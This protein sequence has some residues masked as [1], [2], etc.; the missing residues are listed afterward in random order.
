MPSMKPRPTTLLALFLSALG[1]LLAKRGRRVAAAVIA[2]IVCALFVWGLFQTFRPASG[3]RFATFNIENYPKSAS[4]VEGAFHAIR[5]LDADAIGLQ[6]ITD[7]TG[8]DRAAKERLGTR[9]ST[10]FSDHPEQRVGVLYDGATFSVVDSTMHRETEVYDGAKPALE[11]RLR[12]ASGRVTRMFVV[13]LKARGD[14]GAV[15]KRQL[16]ALAPVVRAARATGDDVIVVGDFNAT[17]PDDVVA[18]RAFARASELDV[19]TEEVECTS[20]WNRSDGCLG[21]PLDHMLTSW[22]AD[23]SAEGACRTHGCAMRPECPSFHR[24]VSDHCPV[25]VDR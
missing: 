22:S 2:V 20:Y 9:W 12:R 11:V 8:F 6:E 5:A 23:A 24:D 14:G 16:D 18:I 7:P 10:V 19:A 15:R 3:S 1:I 17:G 25:V 21:Q 13:H 4:Q